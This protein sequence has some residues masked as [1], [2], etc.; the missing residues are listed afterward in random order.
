[1]DHRKEEEL[2]MGVDLTVKIRHLRR[3]RNVFHSTG[4]ISY[5]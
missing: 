2:G 1:M 4:Y 5:R 3:E